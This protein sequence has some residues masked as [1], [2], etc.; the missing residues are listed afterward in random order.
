MSIKPVAPKVNQPQMIQATTTP[1]NGIFNGVIGSIAGNGSI[2]S[3][4]TT[5]WASTKDT[6][7]KYH[8][9]FPAGTFS[10]TPDCSCTDGTGWFI[11]SYVQSTSSSTQA[12]FQMYNTGT[13]AYADGPFS[14]R[15]DKGK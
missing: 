3:A 5:G 15:C 9:T 14:F 1:Y 7:G 11:C 4:G 10:S 2:V 13:A 12:N 6:T 8:A